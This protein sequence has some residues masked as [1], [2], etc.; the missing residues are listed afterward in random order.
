MLFRSISSSFLSA[1]LNGK[2]RLSSDKAL[3]LSQ[4]IGW[5]WRE[6]QLFL[7]S[8]QLSQAKTLKAKSFLKKELEKTQSKY[9]PFDKMKAHQFSPIS[10]WYYMAILEL[11]EVPDFKAEPSWIAHRLNISQHQA[12]DALE[13]L[14]AARLIFFEDRRWKRNHN[15]LHDTPSK[16]IAKFHRQHLA[17][18]AEAI[19]KQTAQQRHVSGVTLAMDASRLPEAVELI[20]E[21]RSRLCHLMESGEKKNVYHLAVQL[22][23]LDPGA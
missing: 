22:F 14:T 6:T 19:E 17:N 13:K 15:S 9:F 3:Q 4:T 8:A 10:E 16:D 12:V 2:K 23:Q 5:S 20:R 11:T 18:A 21:F 7:Q 1:V